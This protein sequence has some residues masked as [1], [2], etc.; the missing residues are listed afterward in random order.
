MHGHRIVNGRTGSDKGVGEF[1]CINRQGKSV[2][3]YVTCPQVLYSSIKQFDIELPT[4]FS[5]HCHIS[6][7]LQISNKMI[8]D[9]V[10]EPTI[11]TEGMPDDGPIIL[12]IKNLHGM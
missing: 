6:W 1:T 12:L 5:D 2:V 4:V 9:N 3:D 10:I 11:I 7:V 8:T